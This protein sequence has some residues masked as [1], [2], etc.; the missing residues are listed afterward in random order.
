M[1]RAALYSGLKIT[2]RRNH[3]Y[4]VQYYKP[5]GMDATVYIPK[6]DL[7]FINNTPGY[8]LIQGKIEG[9]KFIFQFYGTSDHRKT[10]IDGPHIIERLDNGG[11]RT[12]LTQKVTDASGALMYQT[13][14][15]SKY[16]PASLFPHPGAE[17]VFTEK[18]NDWSEKQ[19]VEYKKIH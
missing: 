14:F 2:E 6:P 7:K 10:D 17:P 8:I 13:D 3:A 1:F 9:T 5:I 12:I 19:W 4:A 18:P 11:L 16:A 15:K